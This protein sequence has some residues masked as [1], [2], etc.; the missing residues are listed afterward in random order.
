MSACRPLYYE[1]VLNLSFGSCLSL[2]KRRRLQ[3]D[4]YHSRI[5]NARVFRLLSVLYI[6]WANTSVKST[7]SRY[8][9][10]VSYTASRILY[11]QQKGANGNKKWQYRS[12]YRSVGRLSHCL[13]EEDSD[14]YITLY[15]KSI[16]QHWFSPFSLLEAAYFKSS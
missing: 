8:Y 14:F 9:K 10:E 7:F 4:I 12:I 2:S 6:Q 3:I 15:T 16:H 5:P 1:K 13:N 11:F